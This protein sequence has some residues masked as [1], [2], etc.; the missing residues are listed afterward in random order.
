MYFEHTNIRVYNNECIIH[1]IVFRVLELNVKITIMNYVI[2]AERVVPKENA[3]R[4]NIKFII[5]HLIIKPNI[6]LFKCYED[7]VTWFYQW[8]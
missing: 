4:M 2:M 8:H 3:R 1:L 5:K 7:P 6:T